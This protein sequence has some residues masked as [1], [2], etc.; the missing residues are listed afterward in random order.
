M[1]LAY[2][3]D[4]HVDTNGP[5]VTEA[6]VARARALAP[7][8]LVLAGDLASGPTTWL[9]TLL[10]LRPCAG[11]L[12]VVAGNHDVWGAPE[13]VAKGL[14]AWK[15]LDHLLPALC[16]EAGVRMLDAGPVEI[17]GIGF[18]GT[19]GWYDLS[20]REGLL[21]A[22]MEAYRKGEWEGLRWTDHQY[23]VWLAPDGRRMEMEEVAAIL[24][25]RLRAHLAALRARRVVVVTH[26]LPF[27]GQIHRKAHPGWRFANAFMGSLPLGDLIRSDSRVFLTI[28]GHTHH[29]SDLRLGGL[30]AVVS[31]LGYRREWKGTTPEEAVEAAMKVIDI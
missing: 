28:S 18:A 31:P 24:R 29:G 9:D 14:D 13:A 8:V 23:A 26:T 19:L 20:T 10:R 27:E 7:D 2:T 11:E 30:R 12:L 25:E 1:R 4:V 21:D 5:A 3:S 15:R 17:G 22:P 6:L 16:A